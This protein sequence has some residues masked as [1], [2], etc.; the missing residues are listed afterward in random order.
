VFS[1]LIYRQTR[2]QATDQCI[3]VADGNRKN[4]DRLKSLGLF[5]NLLPLRLRLNN[6]MS[7]R[8]ALART[9]F[10]SDGAFEHSKIPIDVLL[11]E[12]N[13]PRS[14]SSPLFQAFL[15]YRQNIKDSGTLFGC[16]AEGELVS[17]GQNAYDISID[18]LDSITRDNTITIAVSKDIYTQ[19]EADV[20]LT[21]YLNLLNAFTDNPAAQLGRPPLYVDNG[22]D[23]VTSWALG[24]YF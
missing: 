11:T 2:K 21:S 13:V 10:T 6:E 17:G 23:A 20:L 12:L 7:F 5:L 9:K 22:S 4:A 3:G 1:V 18:I 8:D 15:N 19:P 24:K 14:S 16:Q